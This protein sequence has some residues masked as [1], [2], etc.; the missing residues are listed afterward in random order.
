MKWDPPLDS[1]GALPD[2]IKCIF[3]KQQKEKRAETYENRDMAQFF[4]RYET[5]LWFHTHETTMKPGMKPL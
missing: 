3:D 5:G 2:P 1:S 4:Q